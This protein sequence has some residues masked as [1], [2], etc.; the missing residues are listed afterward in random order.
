[1][2]VTLRAQKHR[3][4][5]FRYK[6]NLDSLSSVKAAAGAD[7]TPR[8]H[9]LTALHVPLHVHHCDKLPLRSGPIPLCLLRC[10][11]PVVRLA[12]GVICHSPALGQPFLGPAC[13][14]T[15]GGSVAA[16]SIQE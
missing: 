14:Q 7:S 15:A 4:A 11:V 1:M 9:G 6:H 12:I 8:S 16:V 10:L 2:T 13:A 5:T 3:A